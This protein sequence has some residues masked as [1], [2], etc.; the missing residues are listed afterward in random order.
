MPNI[1]CQYLHR[2]SDN[3]LLYV[4]YELQ[5]ISIRKIT[6]KVIKYIIYRT[7]IIY[8]VHTK[9]RQHCWYTIRGL[10][11]ALMYDN[12]TLPNMYMRAIYVLFL[13]IGCMDITLDR[14]KN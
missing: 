3:T 4:P 11:L 14:T 2:K 6:K 13:W 12:I 10:C 5:N 9:Y 8:T 7:Y 1:I